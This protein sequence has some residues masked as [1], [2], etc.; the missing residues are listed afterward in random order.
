MDTA[1]VQNTSPGWQGIIHGLEL[2]KRD[3]IWRIEDGKKIRIWRDNWV[4][5][6]DMKVTSNVNN[7]RLRTVAQLINHE[8]HTWKENL[9][10]SVFTSFD[11]KEILKIRL[12]R[13]DEQD[14]IS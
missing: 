1:F 2:L 13:Y 3:I 14:F 5:K 4:P 8:Y 7:S 12:P 10:R 9:V 6:G 11:A